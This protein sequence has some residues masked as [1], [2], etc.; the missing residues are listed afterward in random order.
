MDHKQER[1]DPYLDLMKQVL[2]ASVYDESAWVYIDPEPPRFDK[3]RSPLRFSRDLLRYALVRALRRRSIIAAEW[4][5][6]DPGLRE[7]GRL[8]ASL[9]EVSNIAKRL[10]T[11]EHGWVRNSSTSGQ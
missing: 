10:A 7:E 9:K 11:D 4:R 2:T 8:L 1:I 3:L 5:P 6:F